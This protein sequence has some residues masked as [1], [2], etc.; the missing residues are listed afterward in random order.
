MRDISYVADIAGDIDDLVAIEYLWDINRL[1]SVVFDGKSQCDERQSRLLDL[2]IPILSTIQ[3]PNVFCGGAFSLIV[4][5]LDACLPL[6]H[7]I[8]NGFFAGKNIV[9]AAYAL[10]KFADRLTC[11]SY[12]PNLD[13]SAALRLIS[14]GNFTAVSKNVC[15]HPD[16]VIGKWHGQHDCKP[17]KKLHDL[18]M[19]KEGLSIV[20]GVETMCEYAPV[21]IYRSGGEW[22][23]VL[24]ELSS[25][26]I[27][28]YKKPLTVQCFD[29]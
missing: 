8:L 9:P 7:I 19:V 16:N 1:H 29:V 12:N 20:D 22:G 27:S 23:A 15:H 17:T 21:S 14:Y 18:L 28:I 4:K 2:G 11:E 5:H 3:T 6:K 10:P 24:N 26:K 13:P 25:I